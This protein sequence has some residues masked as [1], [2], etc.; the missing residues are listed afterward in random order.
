[1]I[2]FKPTTTGMIPF[3][4]GQTQ[5]VKTP[6]PQGRNILQ[7]VAGAVLDPVAKLA[8][9]GGQFLGKSIVRGVQAFQSPEQKAKTEV[10][11]QGALSTPSRVP[12]LGTEVKPLKDVGVKDVAGQALG[13]VGVLTGNPMTGGALLGAGG[14]LEAGGKPS[15]V[16]FSGTVNAILGKLADV[17]IQK[18]MPEIQKALTKYGTPLFEKIASK[19]PAGVK[20]TLK[21][22][23]EK[24][25]LEKITVPNAPKGNLVNI[26]LNTNVGGKISEQDILKALPKDV[27]I[28]SSA[29]HPSGTEPTF[30]GELS[31]PL[32]QQ[33]H[34]ALTKALKQDAIPQLVNGK[35]TMT[36]VGEKSWGS[37]NPEYFMDTSGKTLGVLAPEK[38]AIGSIQKGAESLDKK[39]SQT[40][41]NLSEKFGITTPES[42]PDRKIAD[43]IAPKP[44]AR[45]AKLAESKGR[46]F[47]GKEPTLFKA[48]TPDRIATSPEQLEQVQTIKKLIPGAEKMDEPTLYDTLKDKINGVA[49]KL[50]PEL[51]KTPTKFETVKKMQDDWTTIK[52]KQIQDAPATEEPNVMKRQAQFE[53]IIK[54]VSGKSKGN[55]NDLWEVAK[56][57]DRTI[58]EAVKKANNLSSESLQMRKQEWLQNRDIFKSAIKDPNNGLGETAREPFRDMTNMYEAQQ[59]IISKAEVDVKAKGSKLSEFGKS[60]GGKLLKGAIGGTT[61]YEGAKALGVPLP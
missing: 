27:K 34:Y 20:D 22:F 48:G 1:M 44:T 60:T 54:K 21:T 8:T 26:G 16:V 53:A 14:A 51:E 12:G 9:E 32:T 40:G 18:A 25:P 50:K 19:I 4:P 35:G 5:P 57:Y 61:V 28:L 56:E 33:E 17:G 36:N 15:D 46:L 37:F 3:K 24:A 49:T 59:G 13:V 11:L 2:P 41:K 30:V 42:T 23:A 10:K 29:T 38:S 39:I 6:A 58:P 7:S 55:M 31:R 43:L 45:E 47:K 52:A